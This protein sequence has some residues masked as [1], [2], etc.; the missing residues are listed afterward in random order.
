LTPRPFL[1]VRIDD[2]Q[3]CAQTS[4]VLDPV[5]REDGYVIGD[6]TE[7]VF[8]R[9]ARRVSEPVTYCTRSG[10]DSVVFGYG[11]PLCTPGS[12]FLRVRVRRD[13]RLHVTRDAYAVLP[14]FYGQAGECFVLSDDYGTT[15]AVLSRPK[16][17]LESLRDVL[18]PNPDAQPLLWNGLGVLEAHQE[19]TREVGGAA[20]I[21]QLR[22]RRWICSSDAP[23]S[24]PRQF[25]TVLETHLDSFIESR[26]GES[27]FAFELSG[28]VDSATLPLYFARTRPGLESPLCASL[29]YPGEF[30]DAQRIKLGLILR[31]S[32]GCLLETLVGSLSDY[33]LLRELTTKPYRP[34]YPFTDLYSGPIATMA[35]DLQQRGVTVAVTGI[36]GDD[37]FENTVSA[38]QQLKFGP[39]E[40]ARRRGLQ[41]PPYFT[42]RFLHEYMDVPNVPRDVLPPL[43]VSLRGGPHSA[44]SLYIARGVWPVTPFA[45]ESLYAYCQGL[46][47]YFRSNKK[48]LRL[49]HEAYDVP[50]AVHSPA[51]NEHLGEFF[52]RSLTSGRYDDVLYELARHAITQEIEYV[53]VGRLTET[54]EFC[55]NS[56]D[57]PLSRE[58][59]LY[60]L[61]WMIAE[62]NLRAT[63]SAPEGT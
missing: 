56:P 19:L 36:G 63:P 41:Y 50:E 28:G 60:I 11:S 42:R 10:A 44:S 6:P 5:R 15:A 26:L 61:A 43:S 16:L 32:R 12:D 34:F 35:A 3:P 62:V 8:A 45:D 57:H 38:R 54:Y 22:R 29:I 39:E 14:L 24:D 30:G 33:P 37:L 49:Y 31:Q 51:R 55:K 53:D 20:R 47:A 40:A 18:V 48:I 9:I 21:R 46:P 52:V 7:R 1:H 4:S 27:S 13:G 59:L 25:M 17:D 58:W 23:S 2:S